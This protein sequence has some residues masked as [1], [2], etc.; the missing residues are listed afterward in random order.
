MNE[1]KLWTRDFIIDTI[2]NFLLLI[3]HFMP[4]VTIAVYAADHYQASPGQTGLVAGIYIIGIVFGRNFAGN[5]IDRTGRKKTLYAG[6]SFF[7]ITTVLYFAV[8]NS[9]ILLYL[10]RFLHGASFGIAATA[11][12]TIAANIIPIA[13]I[14]E[15]T[16]YYTMSTAIASAVGPFVA[17]LIIQKS[18]FNTILALATILMIMCLVIVV[19]LKVPEVKLT[20]EQL[21]AS[22]KWSLENIIETSTVPIAIVAFLMGVA[23]GPVLQFLSA[24]VRIIDLVDAGSYFFLVYALAMV[25]S[26]T[27]TGRWFDK[28]GENFVMYPSFC[29]FALGLIT[30]GLARQGSVFLLAAVL[31]GVGYGTFFSSG[32]ALIIKLCEKHRTGLAIS[33]FFCFLDSGVGLGTIILGLL[34]PLTGYRGI[35]V[36]VGVVVLSCIVLY[37]FLHGKKSNNYN[38]TAEL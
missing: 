20:E 23:I 14:G 33:T 19:F 28:K 26:R 5:F 34:I 29:L 12:S 1:S 8:T 30:L 25:I 36:C 27:F 13:R 32:Q 37:Y 16:G 3:V 9:L 15:G 35:Y 22:K 6:V 10:V 18:S 2:A 38:L 24:Y 21:E 17:M 11:T 7:L 4:L 31:I